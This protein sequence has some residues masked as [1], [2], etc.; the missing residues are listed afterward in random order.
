M[1]LVLFGYYVV[2]FNWT[3]NHLKQFN[4]L[5]LIK[6]SFINF[7]LAILLSIVQVKFLTS[8]TIPHEALKGNNFVGYDNR[9]YPTRSQVFQ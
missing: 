5:S 4:V 6:K 3:T 2:S 1:Y 8:I 7:F 9:Q